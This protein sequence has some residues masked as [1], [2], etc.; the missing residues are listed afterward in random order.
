MPPHDETHPVAQSEQ[1]PVR[2]VAGLLVGGMLGHL[3]AAQLN[4]GSG[5]A[6]LH[7]IGGFFLIAAITGLPIAGVTWLFWRR[8]RNR[9][10][11]VFALMQLV[12]G[13]LVMV[14]ELRK[15]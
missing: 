5:I 10:L 14:A 15:P 1:P 3:V 12:L 7:H 13:I 8:Q 9:A 2:I 11:L 6:Y 4:G